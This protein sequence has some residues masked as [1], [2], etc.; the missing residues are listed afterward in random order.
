MRTEFFGCRKGYSIYHLLLDGITLG[1][2]LFVGTY[3]P[4]HFRRNE[5]Y[6]L[7]KNYPPEQW[8]ILKEDCFQQKVSAKASFI[9]K[10]TGPAC[11]F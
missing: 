1:H 9:C 4:G 8:S 5:I 6:V 7:I 2:S 10:M 11:Q 3:Q